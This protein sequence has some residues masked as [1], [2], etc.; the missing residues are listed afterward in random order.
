MENSSVNV[1]QLKDIKEERLRFRVILGLNGSSYE[2][3]NKGRGVYEVNFPPLTSFG[4]SGHYEQ[5]LIKVESITL[6]PS[7]AA[8]PS[9]CSENVP[10]VGPT[11]LKLGCISVA[12]STPSS[13][14]CHTEVNGIGVNPVNFQNPNYGGRSDI[15]RFRQM[16]PIQRVDCGDVT[17]NPITGG[18]ADGA[19]LGWR[20]FT[21]S[22]ESVM[23]G[24]P[25]GQKATITLTNPS[26]DSVKCYLSD[27]AGGA[28]PQPDDGDYAISFMIEMIPRN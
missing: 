23:C 22:S 8:R 9:W 13:Q 25:F 6:T 18:A 20:G 5:C 28:A 14:V 27:V 21:D 1:V 26:I 3:E 15:G 24:N 2:V 4:N 10:G 19:M 11:F 16:I 17:G 12:L 7:L